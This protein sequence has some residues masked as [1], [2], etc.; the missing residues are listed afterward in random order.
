MADSLGMRHASNCVHTK[1]RTAKMPFEFSKFSLAATKSDGAVLAWH[2]PVCIA[3][4]DRDRSAHC[5][6]FSP[7]K[8]FRFCMPSRVSR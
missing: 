6:H 7:I 1:C 2:S 4:V 8:S 5:A 3:P